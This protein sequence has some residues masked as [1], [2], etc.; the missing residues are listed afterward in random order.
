MSYSMTPIR[1]MRPSQEVKEHDTA[2]LTYRVATIRHGVFD[3]ARSRW[4]HA[5]RKVS[6]VAILLAVTATMAPAERW[7]TLDPP[8]QSKA[9]LLTRWE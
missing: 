4:A 5:K 7:E 3:S 8:A 6:T 9:S 1:K 2:V